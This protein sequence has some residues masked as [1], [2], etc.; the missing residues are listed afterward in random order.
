MRV[1]EFGLS[2]EQHEELSDRVRQQAMRICIRAL[3]NTYGWESFYRAVCDV[4]E[5]SNTQAF[6]AATIGVRMC[7]E[8]E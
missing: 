3:T 2:D 7:G 8:K 4:A 5:P 6:V 1:N